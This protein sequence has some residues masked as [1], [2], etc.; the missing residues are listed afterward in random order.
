MRAFQ[1]FADGRARGQ[2]LLKTEA[3]QCVERLAIFRPGGKIELAFDGRER[4][5]VLEQARIVLLHIPE[6]GDQRRGEFIASSRAEEMRETIKR[7]LILRKRMGLLVRHHLQAMF[8][9]AEKNVGRGKLVARFR[10]DPFFLRE[11]IQHRNRLAP[12]QFWRAAAGDQLLRLHEKF[13]LTDAAAAQFHVVSL[14][15]DFLMA[16]KS[17]NLPLHVMHVGNGG[18]VEIATPHEGGDF[19]EVGFP[20]DLV[21]A[22][23]ARFNHRGAFPGL[24]CVLVISERGFGGDG[25]LGGA[26]IRAQ[27]EIDT[28]HIS[29][30]RA[31]LQHFYEVAREAHKKRR[32]IEI[33][34]QWRIPVVQHDQIDV[35]RVIQ[36]ARAE[37]AH[38]EH[39]KFAAFARLLRIPDA[40]FF[41]LAGL[42]QQKIH[43][44]ADSGFRDGRQRMGDVVERPDAAHVGYRDQQGR[45]APHCAKHLHRGVFIARRANGLRCFFNQSSEMGF[46]LA[47]QHADQNRR[48]GFCDVPEKRGMAGNAFQ[49]RQHLRARR[50]ERL[51]TG[52]FALAGIF[53]KFGKKQFRAFRIR[54]VRRLADSRRE[55]LDLA[56]SFDFP[57][58]HPP[59]VKKR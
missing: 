32:W 56:C 52:T 12:P 35:A 7:F 5:R 53:Q 10:A 4:R 1:P 16:A 23:H 28:E 20:R 14:D 58:R 37:L 54:R 25:R 13:D 59:S 46:R 44:A 22:H 3:A 57:A 6:M 21:A 34:L 41:G 9:P 49:Q 36:L 27:A 47:L 24:A 38:P 48:I 45:L 30:R 51:E 17:M 19:L 15:R 11:R 31:V 50:S 33:A 18:V 39:E 8:D 2:R 43:R 42:P 26:G 29:V 55:R 40:D